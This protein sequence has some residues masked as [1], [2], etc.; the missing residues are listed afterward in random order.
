M[1]KEKLPANLRGKYVSRAAFAKMQGEKQRLER[2]IY[3]LIIGN[4]HQFREVWTRWKKKFQ[5]DKDF[6]DALREIA[7]R[8]LP[9]LLEKRS[10]EKL[11]LPKIK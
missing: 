1:A 2:D 10:E 8:D 4:T 6:S 9:H 11:S 7:K 3:F 5:Y